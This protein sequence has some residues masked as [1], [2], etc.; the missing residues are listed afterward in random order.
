MHRL[1]FCS[2]DLQKETSYTANAMSE[3]IDLDGDLPL[4]DGYVKARE[5]GT[6]RK[7]G[8]SSFSLERVAIEELDETKESAVM[9][10]R[11]VHADRGK[12]IYRRSSTRHTAYG[13]FE[14]PTLEFLQHIGVPTR[15]IKR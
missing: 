4:L 9:T 8:A 15:S 1:Y 10:S 13:E 2:I 3:R 14:A 5:L 12:G 11:V 7:K 6:L